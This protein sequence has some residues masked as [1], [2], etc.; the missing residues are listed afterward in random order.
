MGK[1]SL[2][3]VFS[4]LPGPS[5]LDLDFNPV[6]LLKDG[7]QFNPSRI[8]SILPESLDFSDPFESSTSILDKLPL[9]RGFDIPAPRDILG[10]DFHSSFLK[11]PLS[12][13]GI[14]SGSF[15][16]SFG[17]MSNLLSGPETLTSYG[18]FG[19]AEEVGGILGHLSSPVGGLFSHIGDIGGPL[20]GILGSVGNWLGPLGGIA[21]GLFGRGHEGVGGM[22]SSLAGGFAFGGPLGAGV[23]VLMNLGL[24]KLVGKVFGGVA[25]AFG[26]VGGLLGRGV[27]ELGGAIGGGIKAIGGGIKKLFGF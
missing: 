11:N 8:S 6:G 2:E 4:G 19:G 23:A 17:F 3:N 9:S 25:N 13:D 10:M 21:G 27:K 14:L 26:E 15:G 12:S 20:G 18:L 7:V 22:L 1:F 5:D 16:D 24:D